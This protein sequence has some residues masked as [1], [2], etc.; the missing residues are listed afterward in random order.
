MVKEENEFQRDFPL[1]PTYQF[2]SDRGLESEM[3][4]IK[5]TSDK[6][7][8]FTTT[9]KR[10]KIINL[11]K[12]NNL[13]D[14]FVDELWPSGKTHKGVNRIDYLARLYQRFI[15]E[16]EGIT[17]EE[18]DDELSIEESQF[19]YEA[20]LQR[21]LAN[22]LHLL[23]KGLTIYQSEDGKKGVEFYIP[24]TQRRIDILATDVNN[25][26]VVIELKVSKGHERT[27]GQALYYQSM[28][29]ELFHVEKVKII[30]VGREIS[31]ELKMSTK[32]LKDVMLFEYQLSMTLQKVQ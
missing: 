12:T 20:D 5:S 31:D 24:N 13:L 29:M 9:L 11:L 18:Y 8:T 22:N 3:L 6:F 21:Y 15:D 7:M 17:S 14:I 19:A 2:L 10:A 30:I 32:H 1:K 16:Q 23:E 26:P 4:T 28:L 27:I 25:I